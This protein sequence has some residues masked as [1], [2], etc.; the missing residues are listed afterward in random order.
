M[1]LSVIIP[2]YNQ[3][4]FLRKNLEVLA[5]NK[6]SDMEIILI[7]GGSTDETP[8]VIREYEAI[9]DYWVSEPDRGQSHALNKGLAVARGHYIGWQNSDDYYLPEGLREGR[10][11][12]QQA[13]DAHS[14]ESLPIIYA[15]ALIV[16][17]KGKT[18]G[19]LYALPYLL[20]DIIYH[21][22]PITNQSAFIPRHLL[23]KV[24]GWN[25]DFHYTMDWDL[26]I[27]LGMIPANFEYHN[28]LWA[29][30][31][32]HD[33]GKMFSFAHG[34]EPVRFKAELKQIKE[35]PDLI[36]KLK[37]YRHLP[38]ALLCFYFRA[39]RALYAIRYKQW[40]K[41]HPDYW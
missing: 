9:L 34:N 7:D 22:L 11:L 13:V 23:N 8:E 33:K 10:Q 29:A 27:K 5:A 14:P 35:N 20:A 21:F 6:T 19:K 38:A 26:F 15:N 25:N 36:E 18:T 30:Y 39:R 12:M 2:S 4:R 1:L 40:T 32:L 24:A 28:R 31:R 41:F 17:E 37:P 16:D 3:G